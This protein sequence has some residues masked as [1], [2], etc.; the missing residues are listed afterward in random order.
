MSRASTSITAT[1][2]G[3]R[4]GGS[5]LPQAAGNAATAVNITV[6]KIVAGGK[7]NRAM[8]LFLR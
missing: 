2:I 1:S 8:N 3:G 7:Q 5:G 4:V 6:R